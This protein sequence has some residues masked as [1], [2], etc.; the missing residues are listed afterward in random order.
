[1]EPQV[2]ILQQILAESAV[3]ARNFQP[4]AAVPTGTDENSVRSYTLDVLA[5]YGLSDWSVQ[6][7]NARRRLGVCKYLPKV[8]GFARHFL[9]VATV[10]QI[11]QTCLH[12]VAHSL[13]PGCHHN[14]V[15]LRVAR[16]MGY[17]GE[18]TCGDV[19]QAAG[20]WQ[21]T[22]PGCGRTAHRYRTPKRL[23]GWHCRKCGRSRGALTWI[24]TKAGPATTPEVG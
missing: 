13:T 17:T 6:F 18:R 16:Q 3:R 9:K 8:I 10:E 7:D 12:E 21:A 24:D 2:N 1:V 5:F 19:P 11:R 15:W 20:R 14:R 22:C 4:Y 23:D